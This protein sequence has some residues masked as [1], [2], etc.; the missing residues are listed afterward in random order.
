MN[1]YLPELRQSL[2]EA[3]RRRA[4]PA[5]AITEPRREWRRPPLGA[6]A[7]AIASAVAI[8]VLVIALTVAGH[9]NHRPSIASHPSVV[10]AERLAAV[11]AAAGNVLDAFPV[12]PGAV[13]SSSD[14]TS[15]ARLGAPEDKLPIAGSVAVHRFWRIPGTVGD[16]GRWIERHAPAGGE[17]RATSELTSGRG[18]S[19]KVIE[20]GG[21]FVFPPA[22]PWVTMKELAVQVAPAAHGV[23]VRADG[24]A[25]FIAPRPAAEQIPA[26]ITRI[27]ARNATTRLPRGQGPTTQ[28]GHIR[29]ESESMT[30][31][32]QVERVVA[33]LNVL[34]P[35]RHRV[36][37]CGRTPLD[38]T[39]LSL[40]GP[41]RGRPRATATV[42][43]SC[44][45]VT[46][47]IADKPK[48][49]LAIDLP[50][51]DNSLIGALGGRFKGL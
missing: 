6:I 11:T 29:F 18:R 5:E 51:L 47:A 14:R 17:L 1:N 2:V 20:W 4:A 46:L 30:S 35:P 15:P 8:A 28:N 38:Q 34:E 21:S 3:A 48:Q 44:G 24:E 16:V 12:P 40:Y 45:I 32:A 36:H 50:G 7:P 23:A 19:R 22:R 10:P 49:K 41:A 39:G 43:Y 42:D 31:R 9:H 37:G 27:V 25:G 26:G 13:G 33:L